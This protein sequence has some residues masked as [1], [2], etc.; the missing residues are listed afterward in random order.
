[1]LGTSPTGT[2]SDLPRLTF[3]PDTTSNHVNT[4]QRY[5]NCVRS[6]WQK[7]N[8]SFTKSKWE[9]SREFTSL[10]PTSNPARS[11]QLVAQSIKRLKVS[12]TMTKS[13]GDKGSPCLRPLEL[14]KKPCGLPLIRIE[15]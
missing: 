5:V 11:P 8:V 15:K 14:G 6:A 12:M 13:K 4:A 1:M 3:E 7:I 2:I 10:E 9:T